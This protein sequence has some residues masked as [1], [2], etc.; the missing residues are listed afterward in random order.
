MEA[1]TE[2]AMNDEIDYAQSVRDRIALLE[3]MSNE[4]AAAA[5][6][7]VVLRDGAADVIRALNEQGVHTAILTGGY[8]RGV[9]RALEK[10]GVTVDD[11]VAN[12]VVVDGDELTGGVEGPLIEGTKD[13]ALANLAETQAVEMADT[14]AVGDGA[15][16]MPMLEVAG[17]GIGF[18]PKPNVE[19]VCDVVVESMAGLH[20]LLVDEGILSP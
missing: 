12:R 18:D 11:I 6:H 14:I 8:E 2:K 1:I 7:E 20:D 9:E 19:P 13:D 17:L 16:D 4:Q 3:G 10:A 15:N 5:F